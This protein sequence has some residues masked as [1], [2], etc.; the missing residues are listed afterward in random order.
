MN[1][2]LKDTDIIKYTHGLF[3]DMININ[4]LDQWDTEEFMEK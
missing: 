1:H 3:D 4:N 2:I